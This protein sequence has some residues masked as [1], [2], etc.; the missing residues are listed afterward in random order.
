MKKL[1][2]A[3]ALMLFIGVNSYAQ[4]TEISGKIIDE[5]GKP[6]EQISIKLLNSEEFTETDQYGDFKI[7]AFKGEK[8]LI[9]HINYKTKTIELRN[10][11]IITLK[12]SAIQ[13]NTIILRADPFGDIAHSDV[14]YDDIKA[15]TQPRNVSD[16]FK[17]IPGFG[18][19]KRGAY[20]SEPV[21]R[22]F[23]YEQLNIQYDGGMKILNACPNRMDPITTHVIPEE[24]EKI[25]VI[26]GPFTVRFGQNF[27]GIINMVSRSI[28]NQKSGF[29]GNIEAGYETNGNNFTTRYTLFYKKEKFDL[30]LNGSYR[31]YGNYTD[32]EGTEVPSTFKTTDYSVKFGYNPKDNQRLK[33]TWRQSFGRDIDHAGLPMDSPYDDSYL[34]GLD[35]KITDLSEK[36]S[37]ISF[38]G[39]YS[40]V[41]HLMTNEN[42]PSFKATFASSNVFATTYGG[43][44]EVT[45]TPSSQLKVFTGIDANFIGRDGSRIRTIKIM[46]GN[47]LP[48][49]KIKVDK[50]WQD[51]EVNNIGVFAEGKYMISD[52]SIITAGLRS[53]FIAT[54]INDPEQDFL[55]L[56]GGEIEDQ[57]EVNI[58]GNVSYVY[59]IN[60]SQWQF[61]FGRGIRTAS[62]IERYINH[63]NIGTDPYEYV[64]N[65][66]LDP[67]I[68]NQFEVSFKQG[69]D[70]FNFGASIFYSFLN[71]YISAVVDKDL[72]RKFMPTVEPIY[73]KR[74]I[75]ID[76]AIQTGFEMFFNYHIT[77]EFSFLSDLSYTYGQNKDFDEPLP[78]VTPLTAHLSLNYDKEKYWFNLKSR[79]VAE[80]DRISETFKEKQTPGFA[81]FDF[82]AGFKPIKGFTVGAAVLNIFDTAY[83]EHLNF[84]YKNS[85]LLS[86]RIYEPGRNFTIYLNYSF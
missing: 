63:F 55:D 79:L 68:N 86:G 60:N 45:L 37:A 42:R 58:S 32:G 3:Y 44:A 25:E 38:K 57:S 51:S 76:K 47:P 1:L 16:L 54:A 6:I 53:D 22:A 17:D 35:Y 18:I 65:P 11:M 15:T 12:E 52:Q 61:A 82:S 33:L 66:Y 67:E 36:V 28:K 70:N 4:Q 74:F 30:E 8:A 29:S 81:L 41:D 24:I 78:Q 39:F 26:R 69:H 7:N 14:I 21:F 10:N 71:D 20:A 77:S 2:M 27:G 13:L 56:Y 84:S 9:S 72:P 80:Q 49:P 34:A 19:Q 23:K 46:N 85:D 50:I 75:N 59:N 83:Y 5:K 31:D 62:M 64:G 48:E 73:A 40:Y 43:K